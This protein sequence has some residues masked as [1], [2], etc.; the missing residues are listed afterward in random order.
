[1]KSVKVFSNSTPKSWIGEFVFD[2]IK[3]R[4]AMG[5]PQK[6]LKMNGSPHQQLAEAIGAD[7]RTVVGGTLRRGPA[8]EILTDQMSGHY[9][10]NWTPQIE[11]QFED[12]LRQKTGLPVNP[13]PN[14]APR[15]SQ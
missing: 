8:G 1:M 4:F 6:W 9:H 7:P 10:Q 14:P 15:V 2:P 3:K 13:P 11:Q 12:F 5:V